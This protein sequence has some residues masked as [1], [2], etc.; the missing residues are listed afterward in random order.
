MAVPTILHTAAVVARVIVCK[1]AI[2]NNW[3]ALSIVIHAAPLVFSMISAECAATNS[4]TSYDVIHTA[5]VASITV[6]TTC[7]HGESVQESTGVGIAPGY[8]MQTIGC[9]SG[10]RRKIGY[11]RRLAIV[12]V[13]IPAKNSGIGRDIPC[14]KRPISATS[15]KTS[16]KRNAVDQL[17]GSG[18]IC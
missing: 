3:T 18:S 9:I 1:E 8:H 5:P 16:K 12:A 10:D 4:W 11:G 6:C 17:K 14:G 15:G 13:N 7:G 2:R